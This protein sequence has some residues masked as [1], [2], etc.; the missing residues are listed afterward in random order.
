M[1]F[2]NDNGVIFGQQMITL[3]FGQQHSVGE[4]LNIRAGGG[5]VLEANFIANSLA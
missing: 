1:S 2:I 3:S 5:P 4:N